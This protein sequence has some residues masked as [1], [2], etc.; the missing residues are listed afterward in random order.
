M[1][2]GFIADLSMINKNGFVYFSLRTSGFKTNAH[3]KNNLG[4]KKF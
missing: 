3:S 2:I 1:M 4:A